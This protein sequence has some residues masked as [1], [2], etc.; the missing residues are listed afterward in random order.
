MPVPFDF[1]FLFRGTC[2]LFRES[3]GQNS[4][5]EF[6]FARKQSDLRVDIPKSFHEEN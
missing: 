3:D 5:V 4:F 6:D 2:P 1:V